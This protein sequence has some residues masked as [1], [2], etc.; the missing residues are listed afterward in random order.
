VRKIKTI[1]FVILFLTYYGQA[2]GQI[3]ELQSKYLLRLY[4]INSN[5]VNLLNDVLL[6][7]KEIPQ[8]IQSGDIEQSNKITIRLDKLEQRY[9][10]LNKQYNELKIEVEV[11]YKNEWPVQFSS[12]WTDELGKYNRHQ[13]FINKEMQKLDEECYK[14]QR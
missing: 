8:C 5:L 12:R 1:L 14:L 11:H 10:V 3:D 9:N 7:C 6:T 4:D 2:L 13:K